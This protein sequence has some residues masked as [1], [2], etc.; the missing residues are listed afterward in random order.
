MVQAVDDVGKAIWY[1]VSGR[2]DT[3]FVK[4]QAQ[5]L[6]ELIA[7]KLVEGPVLKDDIYVIS[8]FKNVAYKLELFDIGL[9]KKNIGTVHTFQGKEAKIVYFVLGADSESEGSARWAFTEPNIV[10][11][12]VTRAKN[13]F[14]VIGEHKLY[15]DLNT[16]VSRSLIK[17]IENIERP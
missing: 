7:A 3:K 11:V 16:S 10:N 9:E 2:A 8:P 6:K 12:A 4:E 15:Q 17:N 13:E 5:K 1:D 14:Y